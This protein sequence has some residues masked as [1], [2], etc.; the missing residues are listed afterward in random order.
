MMGDN[1]ICDVRSWSHHKISQKTIGYWLLV[2]VYM[3]SRF[4]LKG[5]Q[6]GDYIHAVI[7][8]DAVDVN[9]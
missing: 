1:E 4:D 2:L 8:R 6:V 5:F 3:K 7:W 9:G